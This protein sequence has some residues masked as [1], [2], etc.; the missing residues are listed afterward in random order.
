M[1]R[2]GI[3]SPLKQLGCDRFKV[4]AVK[5]D[6]QPVPFAHPDKTSQKVLGVLVTP[7]LNWKPQIHKLLEEAR[8]SA[9]KIIESD[10]APRQK[11]A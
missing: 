10:A 5:I 8:A 1:G 2:H 4:A 6:S 3:P 7:T 9:I 11:L